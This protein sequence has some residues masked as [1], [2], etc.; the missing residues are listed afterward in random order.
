MQ[1]VAKAQPSDVL[2]RKDNATLM[3][4]LLKLDV[5]PRV[6]VCAVSEL[7]PRVPVLTHR[8]ALSTIKFLYE[9]D[10]FRRGYVEYPPRINCA[11]MVGVHY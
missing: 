11:S 5:H 10:L 6:A 9:Y 8:Q 7:P 3:K 1:I 4:E 2:T